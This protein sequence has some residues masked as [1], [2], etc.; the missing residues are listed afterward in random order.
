MD[1]KKTLLKLFWRALKRLFQVFSRTVRGPSEVPRRLNK[2]AGACAALLFAFR[3]D[4]WQDI[5][6][7]GDQR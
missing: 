1:M 3:V 4:R 6:G 7:G 2:S 5:G